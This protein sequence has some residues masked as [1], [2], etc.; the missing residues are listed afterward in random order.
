[1]PKSKKPKSIE[2]NHIFNVRLSDDELDKMRSK[3]KEARLTASELVR[4]IVLDRPLPKP[5]CRVEF[6]TYRELQRIGI[7]L[8]QLIKAINLANKS[9]HQ[10]S[11]NTVE[12]ENLY[13]LL[14]SLQRSITSDLNSARGKEK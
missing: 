6:D 5:I 4:T 11:I 3:A 8:N 12:I 14:L 9:G 13:S 1:M 7:N 2:R 10:P